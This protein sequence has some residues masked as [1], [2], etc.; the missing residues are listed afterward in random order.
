MPNFEKTWGQWDGFH[1]SDDQLKRQKSSSEKKLTP[2]SVNPEQGTGIFKGSGKSDYS[3]TL[4]NCTCIDFSRRKLPCK[5]MYR[6]AYELSL[7][8]P[9]I[10][11]HTSS[12]P[13]ITRDDVIGIIQANLSEDEIRRFASFCYGCG[14]NQE[15]SALFDPEFA[16]RL[17][18]NQLAEEVTDIPTLL[19]HLHIKEVRKF[20]LPLEMKSPRKKSE[21][22][23]LVAPYVSRKQIVF[24]D[25]AKCLTLH[26]DIAYLGHTLHRRLCALYPDI[27]QDIYFDL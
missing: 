12:M 6:L 16:E 5:H 17:I 14:N 13:G 22:I 11:V 15:S 2:I 23:D 10:D 4:S 25:N 7:F 26:S 19:W 18:K 20:L 8:D 1:D 3:T 21:L 27:V 9:G 24:P